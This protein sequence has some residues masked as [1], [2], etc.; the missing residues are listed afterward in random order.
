MAVIDG[1]GSTA[2]K[3]NVDTAYNQ[4]VTLPRL[5]TAD[6]TSGVG[7][8][9]LAGKNDDGT[10]VA[11]GRINRVYVSEG[12]SLKMGLANLLWDDDFNATA[13]NTSAYKWNAT[14]QTGS[15]AG[16]YLILNT[17]AVTT[18]NTNCALQ[19][20]RTFPLYGKAEL[21]CNTS[22]ML[23]QVP[24]ANQVTEFGLFT[25]TLPG[26]AIPTDGV[27]FRYNAAGELRGVINYN[28]TE[29][30]TA[31]ITAPSANVNHD[32]CIVT[33]TNT[34][35]FYIDDILVGKVSLL[36]DAPTLGQPMMQAAV[37]WTARQY[38]GGSAPALATQL[39]V[40]GVF[41]TQLGPDSVQDWPTKKSGYGHM[42]YQGQNGGTVGTTAAYA[43]N[44]AAGAG[45]ALTNT[46][47]LATGL[48]GQA[49]ILPTLAAGT[50]G[51][52]TSF[53]NPAG[54]VNQ[55]PRNLII[56]GVRVQGGVSTI[57]AGGPVMY[58]YSIAYGHTAVSLATAETGSFVVTPTKAPRRIPLGFETY[59]ATAAVGVIGAGVY[60]QFA[61]PITV[62]PGEFIALV[63]KNLGVVTTTGVIV[64]LVEFD[65]Y[66]E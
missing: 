24:Q 2:G 30:Q 37:P 47:A 43:N 22:A 38:I 29:T 17:G 4:N 15:Q 32:F 50:D 63:A 65:G 42:A 19:T 27:F 61:T 33:Q 5:P 28:G 54:G 64:L 26:A 58:A 14:T 46:T 6:S 13:Q 18:I 40:S 35:L 66:F 7:F 55:T 20:S 11:G 36:T 48:G 49:G 25:A 23:T 53:Q 10:L 62:A 41:I 60:V 44:A 45:A 8:A 34:V 1:G 16:G 31:A 57:L 21:R 39:K 56:R 59:A 9:A 3:G 52:V 12:Q 51:I